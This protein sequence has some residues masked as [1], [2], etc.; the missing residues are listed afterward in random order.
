VNETEIALSPGQLTQH[1]APRAALTLYQGED[2]ALLAAMRVTATQLHQQGVPVGLLLAE[3]D[4]GKFVDLGVLCCNVGAITDLEGIAQRLFAAL[5]TLDAA[6]VKHILARDFGAGGLGLA[7]RD[8]LTRAAG[9]RVV[10][11]K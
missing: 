11:V 7:I 2:S 1:Y 3:E 4:I 8:R 6:G 5:R 10:I 9:G